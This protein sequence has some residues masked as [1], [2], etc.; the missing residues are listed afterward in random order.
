MRVVAARSVSDSVPVETVAGHG[1]RIAGVAVV[2]C[3]VQCHYTVAAARIRE[4][5][6]I[7]AARRVRGFVPV[8]TVADHGSRVARV[9]VVH[10][11]VQRHHAIAAARIRVRVRVVAA[12]RVGGSVPV[13]TIA[14]HGSGVAGVAVVDGQVQ[15]N[16]AV[17]AARIRK[18]MR[19]VAARRVRG[20]V[21]VEAV[22]GH[23]GG[24]AG[25]G[26]VHRQVQR[27]HTVA[28][29]RIRKRVRVVSA[30]CVG[31][32]VPVVVI[33]DHSD[34]VA[35][36][37]QRQC[38]GAYH[39]ITYNG[40]GISRREGHIIRQ[41]SNNVIALLVSCL[42]NQLVGVQDRAAGGHFVAVKVGHRDGAA[43]CRQRLQRVGVALKIGGV[44]LVLRDYRRVRIF[45]GDWYALAHPVD[46][47]I[48]LRNC[49]R[50]LCRIVHRIGA[51]ARNG[52]SFLRESVDRQRD[53]IGADIVFRL[54]LHRLTVAHIILC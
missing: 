20:S 30:R 42:Y 15:R 29:A 26:V 53:K 16:H 4:R 33:A 45:R 34:C 40:D 24:V 36:V 5:V 49:S 43:R 12:R 9:A 2:H 17:A 47:V 18:R 22:A 41:T 35:S 10:R 52:S 1:S 37:K 50:E 39:H 14:G 3:Q 11:Q 25:V 6:R 31:K 7:V 54:S 23:G 48:T 32:A 27:H 19:V 46:K 21:P 51:A 8:E 28:A 13:E 44:G 38:L